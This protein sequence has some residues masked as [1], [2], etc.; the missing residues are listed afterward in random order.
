VHDCLTRPAGDADAASGDLRTLLDDAERNASELE[1]ELGD[2]DLHLALYLCYELHYTSFA[3][4]DPGWEWDPL[5]IR[6]RRA[7]E[8]AF[9]AA[10]RDEVPDRPAEPAGLGERLFEIAAADEAPSV[11]R[12]L[13]RD[14]GL[15]H[16]REFVVHRSAYQLKEADPHTWAIPRLRGRAKAAM[17]EV[18]AD[19]YGGGRADRMH[20]ALF[21]KTMRALDLDDRPGAYVGTLPGCTLA[22]VNLISMLGL[23]RALRGALVGHLAMFEMTS[24]GPNRRYGNG[25]RR[26][27]LGPDAT[28]F[29]DEHVEA[30]AVH[31]NIA[32]YDLA[33][34]LARSEPELAA[35]I[36]WGA[37]CLLRL[38]GAGAARMLGCWECGR[39][40]LRLPLSGS[41]LTS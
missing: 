21:A 34:G 37:E 13:E 16:F 2:D 23:N 30:D 11:A 36:V 29:Y 3:D 28:D 38:E 39:S 20:S 24:S 33:E 17:V 9:L 7:L 26:L 27:G 4:V 22:S 41:A 12:F 32:A 6:L 19:E 18:Q 31:E 25:L 35:D 14:A 10:L 40:S 1:Q 5:L 8:D 15:D